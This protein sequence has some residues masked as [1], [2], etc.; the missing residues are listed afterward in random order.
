MKPLLVL[1]ISTLIA[2]LILRLT[3]GQMKI[4]LAA[5]MG[6]STMLL[7]TAMGH[8]MFPEG[9]AK[10]IPEFMPWRMEL[11]YLTAG[12]EILGSIGLHIKAIREIAAWLLII[13]LLLVLPANINAAM[14]HLNY[15]TGDSDGPGLPYLWFRIPLQILFIAWIYG[16]AITH[17]R[18]GLH[19]HWQRIR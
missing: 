3:S 8:F 14:H 17:P 1:I 16:S 15:Q 2:L 5:R 10:M 6:M 11:V 12:L 4:K 9:M 7:F 13:F 18:H 19:A